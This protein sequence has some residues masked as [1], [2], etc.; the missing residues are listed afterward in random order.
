MN[1]IDLK[2][3][4]P[5]FNHEAL[6]SQAVFRVALNALS[7]P[8]RL[9]EMPSQ[10][11]LPKNGHA[12]AALLMLGLLDSECT[13]WLS[14]SLAASDVPAWLRFHT[15]CQVVRDINQAQFVWVGQG[16]PMP[17]L[18]HMNAGN[19]A[20]P[21]QSA[22]CVLE[23]SEMQQDAGGWTLEGPGIQEKQALSVADCAAD[24][25][26]QWQKNHA[27]FPRG[28]DLY[29]VRDRQIAGLPRTTRIQTAQES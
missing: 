14:A 28:V 5:G 18:D 11:G 3:V 25:Q 19:D 6:D 26:A 9:W 24:F 7:Y 13:L 23:V 29:L 17:R 20:Y 27:N 1:A 10:I 2:S 21:D 22:T 15:G 8:G 4:Q 16:D 12:A